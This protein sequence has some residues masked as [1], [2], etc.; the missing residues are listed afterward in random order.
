MGATAVAIVF[1]PWGEQSG[2]HFN[3]AVTLA[4]WR[5]GSFQHVAIV[6]SD[7]EKAYRRLREHKVEHASPG[8]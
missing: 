4:F 5:L 3:P 6:V 1:S 2:A 8:P 7:M